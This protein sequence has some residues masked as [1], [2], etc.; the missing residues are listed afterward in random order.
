MKSLSQL[1][2]VNDEGTN[3]RHDIKSKSRKKRDSSYITNVQWQNRDKS[4][5]KEVH[6]EEKILSEAP[7]D[8]KLDDKIIEKHYDIKPKSRKKRGIL[9]VLQNAYLYWMNKI[10][11]LENR[12]TNNNPKYKIINGVKYVYY[13]VRNVKVKPKELQ[14][15]AN[16]VKETDSKAVIVDDF[17][18]GE[19][20]EGPIESRTMKQ[21]HKLKDNVNETVD[22]IDDNPWE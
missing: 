10:L 18:K 19:I 8:R 6:E 2:K 12:R 13:P 20:V 5:I 22:M 11:G 1:R 3:N 21:F 4:P 16:V 14:H 9:D 15:N 7:L 17:N